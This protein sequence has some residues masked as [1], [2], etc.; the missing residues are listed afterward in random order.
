MDED[1]GSWLRE[2]LGE[3]TVQALKGHGFDAHL[4]QGI[5]EARERILG[6]ISGFNSFGFAGSHTTRSL[7]ILE[8]LREQGK[9]VFDHWREGLSSEEDLRIRMEQGRCDCFFTSA[10]GISATGEIVNVD[11]VGN[12]TNAMTFG[13]RKVI[14]VAGMNKV[15][16]DL[17]GALRRVREV[18]G[19]MRARSLGFATPCAETGICTDCNAPQR[20]CRVTTI[21]H[22]KPMFTD[23]SVILIN[24]SLGF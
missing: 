16:Q 22:R 19:P 2:K 12:R 23:I 13:P 1:Y 3:K 11:G 8:V 21:L 4:V 17:D 24:E 6:M 14:I 9:E 10:N 5:P 7:G 20:I 15:R 18:A